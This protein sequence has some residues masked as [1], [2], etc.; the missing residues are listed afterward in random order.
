[1]V[2]WSKLAV[3]MLTP[4]LLLVLIS[5]GEVTTPGPSPTPA[6]APN[7]WTWESGSDL[8]DQRGVYGTQGVAA[9]GNIPGGR[10]YACSWMDA[11]GN[12][13][14]FGGVGIDS[15][16]TLEWLNDLWKY[17]AGEWTWVSGSNL[18]KQA[19]TY[20]TQRTPAP[21]N[22]PGARVAAVS[23]TDP[24]GNFWLFGGQGTDS[25]GTRGYLNDL[26]KYSNGE[27]AWISG[28]ETLS[29][30]GG[31][32]A[33]EG[34]YG[35]QGTPS[36]GNVPG[37]RF[38]AVSW[39]DSSGNLWLLGGEGWDST[40]ALGILNDLWKYDPSSNMW[41]WVSGANTWGQFGTYGTLGTA[42]PANIPGSRTN[43]ATWIDKSG[44]LWLFGGQG[45]DLNGVRCNETGG[46]CDLNDLWKYSPAT[47]MWTWMG[48]SNVVEQ[49]GVYGTQGTPSPG[50][51]PGA[52]EEAVSWTDAAGNFWLFGGFGFDST[53][54]AYTVFGE[55][56]D[57]WKYSGGEWTWMSGSVHA[58][59]TGIYGTLG[60]A[61][62]GNVPGARSTA[63]SWID[64][65][66]NLWF[67][68]GQN[69]F[70][71]P[72]GKFNDLWMYHP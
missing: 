26:W 7:E 65:S 31:N 49:P 21:A 34:V 47:N 48:G 59:Q 61:D 28:S 52:R 17:S 51:I 42:A 20:G 33:I 67:F 54:G 70:S 16:G 72:Q 64:A 45:S 15:A 6:P 62:P 8:V 11:S 43:P 32:Y 57:L 40:G 44:N 38:D 50:N 39:T 66:G 29:N 63:V 4:I 41:T 24:W 10:A 27:W 30:F 14:L 19:G 71:L 37:A 2:K 46:P 12:L 13:W 55:L 18:V 25:T 53:T 22:V 5:C 68:G 35:I 58:S 1:M 60:V 23:W 3:L 36:P 9:A 56:N 69:I